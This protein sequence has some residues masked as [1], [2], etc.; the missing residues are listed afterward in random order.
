[1]NLILTAVHMDVMCVV[2]RNNMLFVSNILRLIH[3]HIVKLIQIQFIVLL[4]KCLTVAWNGD[5]AERDINMRQ[6][7]IV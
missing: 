2:F 5:F 7:P 6:L 1:M 3:D 4:K